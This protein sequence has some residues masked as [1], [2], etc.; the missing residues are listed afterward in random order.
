[1]IERAANRSVAR[2][3]ADARAGDIK[4]SVADIGRA[5]AE[6]GYEPVVGVEDGLKR[7]VE[8]VRS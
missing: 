8:Y 7:L 2:S 3:F 5:R 4:E 6:L 1:L